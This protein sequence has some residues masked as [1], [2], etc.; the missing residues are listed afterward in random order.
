MF[1]SERKYLHFRFPFSLCVRTIFVLLFFSKASFSQSSQKSSW[2]VESKASYG[3]IACH[4]PKMRHLQQDHLGGVE[5]NIGKQTNGSKYWQ[6]YH[7]YPVMGMMFL[8]SDL[9]KKDVL[10]SASALYTYLNFHINKSPKKEFNFRFAAGVGYLSKCFD[11]LENYKNIA[12]GSH[13]NV[14]INMMYELK[15]NIFDRFQ[16]STSIGLTHFSNGAYKI[17]NLGLNIPTV[18]VGVSYKLTETRAQA[19]APQKNL[20]DSLPLKKEIFTVFSFGT[21][22]IYPP[23]GENYSVYS[24]SLGYAYPL[25]IKRKLI[26]GH[27]LFLDYSNLRSLKR[28]DEA[29]GKDYEINKNGVFVGQEICFSKLTFLMD[30][31]AYYHT[32]YKDDG[33]IYSRFGLRYCLT[34]NLLVSLA[35]KTHYAKADFVGWG[36][37]YKI[38]L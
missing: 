34:K 23:S 1:L 29:P 12:I 16:A 6:Q 20:W 32:L 5:I 2:I 21:K 10:G 25:S 17:P 15:Y 22:Q 4:H 8:R 35:L 27:D 3:F 14:S 7:K 30:L 24:L 11:P 9:G 28:V 37:G 36:I 19:Q 33:Y 38:G 18:N 31:G 26:F 13:V